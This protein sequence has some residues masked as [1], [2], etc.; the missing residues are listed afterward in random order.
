M[1]DA[2]V[3][4][5]GK[6]SRLGNLTKNTP[7][8]LLK[9][10]NQ[11]FLDT[12]IAKLIKYKFNK[13]YLLCSFKKEKFFRLY[14]NK[15]IHN[16]KIMCIDE[17]NPK[18]TGGALYKLKNIVKRDFLLINGDT[19]FDIDI[20]KLLENKFK[21][22]I[23]T[24]A[25]TSN[26]KYKKN[27]KINNI[28]ININN[29]IQFSKDF[30]SL[31]NGGIYFFKKKIFKF[32]IKKKCSLENDI[33]K[34][35]IIKKKIHGI[36][37]KEKFV[38]IGSHK[39]IKFL[40][41]N[42]DFFKQKAIFLDRDGVINRLKKNDYIKKYSEF[43]FLPG[44]ID[45]IKYINKKNYLV[46][47]ITNQACIGKSII[48]EKTLDSIHDKMKKHL[49]SKKNAHIDDIY[50]SPYYKYSNNS[51]YRKNE[52]DRKPNPGMLIKAIKKWNVNIKKSLFL[53]DSVT[54]YRLSKKMRIK[55]YYKS[56]SKLIS[57]LR[58]II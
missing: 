51:K 17:G 41:K 4:V 48:S 58:K 52:F 28:K 42:K 47:I 29:Q 56:N 13:I 36:V 12:I 40:K 22:N 32:I 25:L 30:S 55:F 31:M 27:I 23:C 20:S 2:V 50:Y 43:N 21:D 35:L 10:N 5:G 33:L 3:L 38:D 16:S 26:K 19:Y 54:D 53:G 45:G 8:P 44:V 34:N 11:I 9:I 37:F 57:Q 15:I 14:N 39:M 18:G 46:I 49:K 1:I 24:I 6:G 7:K